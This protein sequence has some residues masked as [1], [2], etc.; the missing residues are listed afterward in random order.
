MVL[1]RG[2]IGEDCGTPKIACPLHKKTF[3]LETGEN[4]N[5]EEYSIAVFPVKIEDGFVYIGTD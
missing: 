5:G 3:S 1:S 2:M 4:L